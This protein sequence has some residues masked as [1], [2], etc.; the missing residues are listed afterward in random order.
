MVLGKM[1]EAARNRHGDISKRKTAG[2][3]TKM[4]GVDV[5]GNAQANSVAPSV[6]VSGE[7]MEK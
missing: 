2:D 4:L 3:S 7:V 1:S 5:E 6:I